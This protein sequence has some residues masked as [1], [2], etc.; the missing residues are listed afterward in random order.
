M[1]ILED[2]FRTV[3]AIHQMAKG[4]GV[5][6]AKFSGHAPRKATPR[7]QINTRNPFLEGFLYGRRGVSTRVPL[8]KIGA[9]RDTAPAAQSPELRG[10][11][12]AGHFAGMVE[13]VSKGAGTMEKSRTPVNRAFRGGIVGKSVHFL[14]K[15]GKKRLAGKGA[16]WGRKNIYFFEDF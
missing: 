9:A 8:R 16:L 6:E 3:A 12:R 11:P 7:L 4:A 14:S 5:L 15:S 13:D 10:I 1:I 2:E